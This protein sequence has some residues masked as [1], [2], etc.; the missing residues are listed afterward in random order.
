MHSMLIHVDIIQLIYHDFS[1]ML[2]G[3]WAD[4]GNTA[5]Q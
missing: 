1:A 4:L 5:G 2:A 3:R